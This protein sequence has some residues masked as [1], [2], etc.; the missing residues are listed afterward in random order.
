MLAIAGKIVLVED[1]RLTREFL[2]KCMERVTVHFKDG[3]SR[4]SGVLSARGTP[5]IRIRTRRC[6]RSSGVLRSR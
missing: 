2:L 5:T 6:G 4:Q 1:A 3:T